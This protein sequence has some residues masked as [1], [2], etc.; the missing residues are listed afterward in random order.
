MRVVDLTQSM[1]NGMPV[2]EGITPPSFRDLAE[3]VGVAVHLLDVLLAVNGGDSC[4]AAHAAPRWV[5]ASAATAGASPGLTS[6]PQ[7][8]S[9]SARPAARMFFAALTSR[10]W[11]APQPAHCQARTP[12]GLGPSLTPHAEHTC[13]VG[14]NRPIR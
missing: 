13:E 4:R 2:M 6:P 8:F 12:S 3:V 7:A 5:P 9:L 11:T 1:T 10:S 14:S